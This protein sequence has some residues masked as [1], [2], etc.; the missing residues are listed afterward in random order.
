M[1]LKGGESEAEGSFIV[2]IDGGEQYRGGDENEK[3][4]VTQVRVRT[5]KGQS[6]G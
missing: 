6:E 4:K 2:A 5:R 3:I 1:K